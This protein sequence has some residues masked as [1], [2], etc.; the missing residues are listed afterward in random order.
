[1]CHD[2]G[3]NG[4]LEG[5]AVQAQPLGLS[6]GM[7]TN[8]EVTIFSLPELRPRRI[9]A[10][11]LAV[12][13]VGL[14]FYLLYRF[15]HVLLI[16]FAAVIIST[17][18]K[19]LVTRLNEFGLPR[20][21]GVIL[22]FVVL[23]ALLVGLALLLAPMAIDQGL[24][25]VQSLPGRYIELRRAMLENSN[26]F[27]WRLGF[28]MPPYLSDGTVP[29]EVE[30]GQA[31][32]ALIH[33]LQLAGLAGKTLFGVAA[34]LILAFLWTLHGERTVR[35]LTLLLPNGRREAVRQFVAD[36]EVMVGAFIAGQAILSLIVGGLSLVAFL[37]LGLPN[38]LLLA[39]FAGLMEAVPLLG[40][41]IGTVPAALVGYSVSPATALG[42]VV[43][44]AIIQQL[45][46]QLLVPRVM[47]RSLGINP[48]VTLLAVMAFGLLFGLAGALVAIPL[49]A[50]IQLL[51]DRTLLAPAEPAG[52]GLSGR[53][54][55]SV[56]RLE[57][58]ELVGDLRQRVRY[59]DG[60]A[61][62][63][64]DYVED[65]LEAIASDLESLLAGEAGDGGAR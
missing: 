16:F 38:A 31:A 32:E 56:L 57:V 7:M 52:E 61:S 8:V 43:A 21:L 54:Q 23:L 48:V 35:G 46:N 30:N 6:T 40:P 44:M 12:V 10:G 29:A 1:V 15:H 20:W 3:T 4:G 65:E 26:Y 45:E 24:A 9:A 25:F 47:K 18:I 19:P 42:V 49:A 17:A 55:F 14:A 59:K 2:G 50:L 62:A 58:Q 53:D 64:I 51:L 39:I 5:V 27:I 36:A 37:A 28:E 34:T 63:D 41:I 33:D 13:L 60:D 22:V 11:T